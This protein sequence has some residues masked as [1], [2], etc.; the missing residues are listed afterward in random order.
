MKKKEK[1]EKSNGTDLSLKSKCGR[2]HLYIF[3]TH[4]QSDMKQ[5]LKWKLV[6][7]ACLNAKCV[8]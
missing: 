2:G 8:S 1:K 4:Q 5:Y 6:K 3:E 7:T